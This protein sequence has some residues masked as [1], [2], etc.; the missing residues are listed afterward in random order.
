[1]ELEEEL[2]KTVISSTPYC[3]PPPTTEKYEKYIK[4]WLVHKSLME[5]IYVEIY[6]L[7]VN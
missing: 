5:K 6:H 3:P 2:R 7:A 4:I 1:M